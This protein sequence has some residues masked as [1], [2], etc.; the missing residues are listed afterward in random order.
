[1]ID[2]AGGSALVTGGAGG[3]GRA[4]A[5]RLIAT[6]AAVVIADVDADGSAI[7]A[8]LG[9]AYLRTDVSR[10]ADLIAAVAAAEARGPLRFV[11]LNAGISS[12]APL[13]AIDEA[14]YRRAV[15]VNLDGV[16]WGIRA[17]LPAMRRAGGGAIV[18]TSSLA[19]LAP[20]PADVIYSAT[21]A[22]VIAL[23]RSLG[24]S[25]RD[26]GVRLN[27]ICP[28]FADTPMV[29]AAVREAGFPLLTVGEVADAVL[30]IAAADGDSQAYILQ[31]GRDLVAYGFRGV[32]GARAPDE[33]QSA[34]VPEVWSA[35]RRRL[36]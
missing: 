12:I 7:A 10:P 1:M 6:G 30:S 16:F 17:A 20:Q 34:V 11:H 29:P 19:G 18:A 32:P 24:P 33:E 3:I 26:R 2:L 4:V 31:P 8:Q 15:G 25:L 23:V 36:N 13:E 28:G 5:A 22:A 14:L 9:A 27:C 35:P 21:K